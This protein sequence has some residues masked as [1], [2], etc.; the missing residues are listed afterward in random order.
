MIPGFLVQT[1]TSDDLI[2]SGFYT[3][4]DKSKPANIFIHGFTSD[5]Y[6]HKF[7]N[8]AIKALN[9]DNN[10]AIAIQTRGTGIYTE[11]LKGN[12]LDGVN[13][14]SYY[15]K[16]EEA[17]LD[18]SAWIDFLMA[19]GYT[20]FNLIGH[21]LGTIKSV[22]YLFEGKYKNN[23]NS[24][25]L[26]APFDKNGY[27][28]RHSGDKFKTRLQDVEE[29][30]K[31]GK[32]QEIVPSDY[33][34]YP[35]S[36]DTYKSWYAQDELSCMFDFYKGDNYNYPILSQ[37]K[38]PVQIIVGDKDEYFYINEF[39]N[40]NQVKSILNNHI[41]NLKLD[42]INGADHCYVGYEHQVSNLVSNFVNGQ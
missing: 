11:F 36:Y 10:C 2:L 22:R 40:L 38:I 34:D 6:S 14:G 35:I 33:E 4:G 20:S 12:W 9:K 26:L 39:N 5:F 21:S 7:F 18:I 28:I 15:E 25:V 24:L 3:S 17:N 31:A 32:G 8:E 23:I 30:I 42:I 41:S 37:I 29:Q 16:L 19:Q 13:I 1:V 27:I